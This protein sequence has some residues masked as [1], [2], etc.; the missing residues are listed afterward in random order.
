[1]EGKSWPVLFGAGVLVIVAFLRGA[2]L[3]SGQ[4]QQ[5]PQAPAS[6]KI[7][8]KKEGEKEKQV[9]TPPTCSWCEPLGLY[10]E[11]FAMSLAGAEPISD[12]VSHASSLGYDLDTMVALIPD[13][14]DSGLSYRSSEALE[15]IQRAFTDSGFILDRQWYPWEGKAATDR[16]YRDEPGV[17]LFRR[18]TQQGR[19]LTAVFLVGETPKGGIHKAA[20]LGALAFTRALYDTTGSLS[21]YRILGPSF[22]GSAESLRIALL[23]W[24]LLEDSGVAEPSAAQGQKASPAPRFRIVTGSAT[25]SNVRNYF[26]QDFGAAVELEA[27]ILPDDVLEKRALDFLTAR[28]R[29]R[30]SEIALLTESD[31]VYGQKFRRQSDPDRLGYVVEFP[32]QLAQI[33]AARG[34]Q[35]LQNK[36]KDSAEMVEPS[37]QALDLNLTEEERGAERFPQF[38][39]LPNASADLSLIHQ[40]KILSRE[41]IKYVGIVASDIRDRLFLVE[42]VRSY[43]P[44][45]VVFTFDNHLL[46]THPRLSRSL[47]GTLVFSSF[48]LYVSERRGYRRQDVSEF[49][50]GLLMATRRLLGEERTEPNAW[51]VAVGNSSVWPLAVLPGEALGQTP[52][53]S[54]MAGF[55]WDNLKWLLAVVIL[56]LLAVWLM[57]LA[58]P[59]QRVVR[60]GPQEPTWALG[61]V[62]S[63]AAGFTALILGAG[64]LVAFCVLPH[65]KPDRFSRPAG[66]V[67]PEDLIVGASLLIY[68]LVVWLGALVVIPPLRSHCKAFWSLLWGMGAVLCLLVLTEGVDRLWVL[69]EGADFFYPRAAA[70]ASGLSPLPAL[71][72]LLGTIYAWAVTELKRRRLIVLQEVDWPFLAPLE[73]PLATCRLIAEKLRL[74]LVRRFPGLAFWTILAVAFAVVFPRL[75]RNLQPIAEKVSYGWIFMVLLGIGFTLSALLFHR[76]F[77]IWRR[78]ERILDRLCHTWLVHAFK[79]HSEALDWRPMRSFGLRMPRFRMSLLS[80]DQL[81]M[82]S[83]AGTLGRKGQDLAGPRGGPQ[84][85]FDKALEEAFAAELRGDIVAEVKAR[86][87]VRE[88]LAGGTHALED[89]WRNEGG[90]DPAGLPNLKGESP[91]RPRE[92]ELREIEKLFA[93]RVVAYL[94]YVFAHLRVCLLGGLTCGLL[95]LTAA[96]IYAFQP[97]RFLSFGIWMALLFAAIMTLRTFMQMDRNAALSAIA[98]TD[99]GKLSFDRTFFSNLV[100]YVGVPVFGIVVTQFPAVGGLLGDWVQPLLRLLTAN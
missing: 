74:A 64:V 65:W 39:P 10:E 17:L 37:Q 1:M 3:P 34:K 28:L 30:R 47:D 99:A 8:D 60:E 25:A 95:V 19:L 69:P 29:W 96:S 59:L 26:Q 93:L 70:L 11:F 57:R 46:Q 90:S 76:F 71:A 88:W 49:R 68:A 84:N 75:Y 5:Q 98:G 79:T 73:P 97:K 38:G 41:R 52:R 61:T 78:L 58:L 53:I 44:D 77:A 20:F 55:E 81:E 66:P 18:S 31:T 36:R 9:A 7:E 16:R 54:Q 27:A 86:H 13:P 15:A 35:G 2:P 72:M 43:L 4:P 33:R 22:S 91:P 24:K 40:L 67:L 62:L 45:A 82:L 56:S 63:P 83:R 87:T 51:V 50:Q 6:E 42:R 48:P 94:R 14:L 12:L 21:S 80:A 32:L 23:Q 92:N 89:V 100:T 85:A